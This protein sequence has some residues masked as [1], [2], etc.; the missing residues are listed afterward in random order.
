[1]KGGD[2]KIW[3]QAVGFDVAR[4]EASL[5]G[6]AAKQVDLTLANLADFHK[7][8]S[9]TEWAESLP[10]NTPEDRR[11]KTVFINNC[12]GCHQVS[13]LLQNRFDA[14]GWT[15]LL[16]VMEKADGEG[17]QEP[18]NRVSP[19]IDAYKQELVGYLTRVR[20]PD[21]VVE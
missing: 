11:L 13:F 16:N 10:E 1:M 3:A 19:Y 15:A 12:S 5:S 7:Q 14:T 17:R 2:Y 18:A 21:S 20:G 6:G 4:A 8:L 9:G